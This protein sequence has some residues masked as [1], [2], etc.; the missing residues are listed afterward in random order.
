M[1]KIVLPFIL[2]LILIGCNSEPEG[3]TIT[4]TLRGEVAD[5][6]KVIM[7]KINCTDNCLL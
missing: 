2:G 5:S 3:Y 1:K 4:G 7:T 6:T